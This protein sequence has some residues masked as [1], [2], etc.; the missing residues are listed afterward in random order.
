MYADAEARNH[1][2]EQFQKVLAITIIALD[3]TPFI[4]AGG[5]MIPTA[6]PLNSNGYGHGAESRL[7]TSPVNC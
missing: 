6:D 3:R 5:D 2:S 4:A 7:L 1:L